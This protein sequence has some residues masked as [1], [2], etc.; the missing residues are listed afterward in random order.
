MFLW[1]YV[2]HIYYRMEGNK[3]SKSQKEAQKKYDQKT[4]T[5]SVKY[6]PADMEDY[7]RMKIYLEKTGKSTNSFI[8]GLINNFFESG[9]GEIYERPLEK[10][11]HNTEIFYKYVDIKWEDI[12]PLID[13][14]GKLPIQRLLSKYE[15]D[16]KN[17]VISER[18]ERET[19]MLIWIKEIT[20]RIKTDEFDNYSKLECC[21]IL[22]NEMME[23]LK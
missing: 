12:S 14:F 9:K 20:N 22:E 1:L 21:H 18:R 3:V 16:F 13:Y 23:L 2:L 6:T 5:V 8:K 7:N 10:R 19:K 11:L 15:N 17:M 4:K